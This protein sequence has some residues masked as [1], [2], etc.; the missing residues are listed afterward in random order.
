M[1]VDDEHDIVIHNVDVFNFCCFYMWKVLFEIYW[2]RQI[3]RKVTNSSYNW[4]SCEIA[5]PA[6]VMT[7]VYVNLF[8]TSILLLWSKK[9]S[10]DNLWKSNMFGLVCNSSRFGS[11]KFFISMFPKFGDNLFFSLVFRRRNWKKSQTDKK[12]STPN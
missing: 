11:C 4:F 6:R 9:S 7:V 1:G 10:E 8:S 3:P 2:N 12:S 5:S